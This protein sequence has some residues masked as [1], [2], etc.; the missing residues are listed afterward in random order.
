MNFKMMLLADC[1]APNNSPKDES[2]FAY[3]DSLSTICEV[4]AVAY[5]DLQS[6]STSTNNLYI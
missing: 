2:L 5:H 1:I 3:I 6:N 4:K